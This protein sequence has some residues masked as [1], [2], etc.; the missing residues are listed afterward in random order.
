MKILLVALAMLAQAC[1]LEP[2]RLRDCYSTWTGFVLCDS[3]NPRPYFNA[4]GKVDALVIKEGWHEAY[5]RKMGSLIIGANV[6]SPLN[7]PGAHVLGCYFPEVNWIAI[8]YPEV[9]DDDMLI[10][11]VSHEL[12]HMALTAAGIS[13]PRH[14][15]P[16]WAKYGLAF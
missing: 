12:W 14:E 6:T 5:R 7:C 9:T 16:T 1:V 10:R 8:K 4:A 13:D 3:H 2:F 15:H 11:I